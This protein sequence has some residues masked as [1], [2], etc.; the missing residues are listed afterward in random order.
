MWKKILL[1][2]IIS[3]AVFIG[4][5]FWA[6]SGISA[7]ADNFFNLLAEKN[8]KIAYQEYLSSDFKAKIPLTKFINYVKTN[9]LDKVKETN[10]GN[11]QINGNLGELEGSLITQ[12][13]SAIP[14]KLKF[15]K[16]DNN[17]QIYSINKPKSGISL[18]SN[19][20]KNTN[21]LVYKKP[22]S[23]KTPSKKEALILLTDSMQHFSYSIKNKN[24]KEF[25][26]NISDMW[27]KQTT[28]EKLN[29]TF[30]K[31]MDANVN[32]TPLINSIPEIKKIQ[33]TPE[34]VLKINATYDGKAINLKNIKIDIDNIYINENHQW[35]LLGFAIKVRKKV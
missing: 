9:N 29:K 26:D 34:G 15:V 30:K 20:N 14:I 13:G 6:T 28:L 33:I 16:A 10:W 8:Y 35:K 23:L 31:L 17:W 27:Q 25:Y 2:F 21:N 1:G 24:M 7:T 3:I 19:Q 4:L 32:L 12:D 5:I 18:N 11:R 22:S